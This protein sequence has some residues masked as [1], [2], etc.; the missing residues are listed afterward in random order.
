MALP[1]LNES[2]KYETRIPSLNKSVKFRPYL[3]KEEKVLMLAMESND[4]KQAMG[5]IADTIVACIEEPIDKSSLTIFDIEYLFT[6]IRSKS[7]GETSKILIKCKE[8]E[9]SNEYTVDLSKVTVNVPKVDKKVQLTDS[10][11][12][13]LQYPSFTSVLRN[14]VLET[15]SST[16]QVF[17]LIVACIAAIW[18]DEERIDAKE[19]SEKDLMDFVESM[20]SVQFGKIREWVEKMPKLTHDVDFQCGSCNLE[21]HLVLEGMSDFF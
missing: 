21:N 19:E 16:D 12:V 14:N 4:P 11:W 17:R 6:Q 9:A 2:P 13:E 15:S 1:R 18:T 8:C 20:D 10:I 5:A 3:V 7:V